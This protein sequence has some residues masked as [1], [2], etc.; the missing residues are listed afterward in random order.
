MYIKLNIKIASRAETKRLKKIQRM[1][2][3][4]VLKH[5]LE[6]Q[7]QQSKS[8]PIPNSGGH[9]NKLFHFSKEFDSMKARE[10]KAKKATRL[11]TL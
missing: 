9:S 7:M 4:K 5:Q 6:K 11:S 10:Q 2:E 1:K 3:T 8:V